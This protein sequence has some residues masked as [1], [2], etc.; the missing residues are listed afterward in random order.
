MQESEG[1]GDS[2]LVINSA[3][4]ID[5]DLTDQQLSDV[6]GFEVPGYEDLTLHEALSLTG[7]GPE[8]RTSKT[9]DS[10]IAQR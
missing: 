3:G 1:S 6:F 2:C 8:I 10:W 7:G 4:V 5:A 9:C